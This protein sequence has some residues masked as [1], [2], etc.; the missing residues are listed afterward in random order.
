LAAEIKSELSVD[1]EL[2]EGASGIFDV[3]ADGALVYSK[4]DTGRF[5]ETGE[6]V[7]ALRG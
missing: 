4:H 5:P 6:V 7:A 3:K 1:A 2:I